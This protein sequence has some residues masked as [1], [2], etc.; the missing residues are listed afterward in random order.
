ML[1]KDCERLRNPHAFDWYQS[2]LTLRDIVS[3]YAHHDSEIL[4]VGCGNSR[5]SLD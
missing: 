2:W 5:T 3:Q 4:N 1:S